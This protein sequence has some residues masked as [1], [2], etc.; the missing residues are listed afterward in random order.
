[1]TEPVENPETQETQVELRYGFT[2]GLNSQGELLFE[3]H[4]DQMGVVE[5]YGL[6]TIAETYATDMAA[7]QLNLPSQ[8]LQTGQRILSEQLAEL[9]N[10]LGAKDGQED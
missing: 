2:V 7:K 10:Q 9:R 3:V 8:R 5:L 1:M 4:G 6:L